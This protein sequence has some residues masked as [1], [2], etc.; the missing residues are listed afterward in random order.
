MGVDPVV[1]GEDIVD[2]GRILV[3]TA[4]SIVDPDNRI[5]QNALEDGDVG[6]VMVML[7][8]GGQKGTAREVDYNRGRAWRVSRAHEWVMDAVEEMMR[9]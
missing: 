8:C 9:V 4:Q 6:G 5:G 7:G 3:S 2:W 1:A